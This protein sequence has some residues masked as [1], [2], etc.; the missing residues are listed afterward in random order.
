MIEANVQALRLV[1]CTARTSRLEEALE[2]LLRQARK[3]DVDTVLATLTFEGRLAM[4]VEVTDRGKTL[5]VDLPSGRRRYGLHLDGVHQAL[6]DWIR[7]RHQ[8]D[9]ALLDVYERLLLA[10]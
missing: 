10:G 1:G 5:V 7:E 6:A 9:P 2:H 4:P 8:A 3:K